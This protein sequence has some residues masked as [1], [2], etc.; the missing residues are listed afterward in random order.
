MKNIQ[1]LLFIFCIIAASLSSCKLD[2]YDEP[3]G[4]ITGR[5]I[6]SVT[7]EPIVTEQP[8][9]FRI[10][11]EE[12]SWSDAPRPEYFWGKADGT[13]NNIRL[14]SGTY[15]VTPVEGA[16]DTPG[17]KEVNITSGGVT[18][19]D[20]TVTPYISFSDVSIV[21]SGDNIEVSFKLTKNIQDATL[22][23]YRIFATYKTPFV[24]TVIFES[25]IY[26]GDN[27]PKNSN[28]IKLTEADLNKTL[29]ETLDKITPG[30]LWYV[31]V[32]ARC[33]N[34]SSRYNMS[35]V[36]PIQM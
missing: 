17:A 16:F 18:T 1:S 28:P 10:K 23:D 2:N 3:D 27:N 13:F 22:Q 5:V 35:K 11:L 36:F 31:R 8:D 24:G 14:F 33:S 21:K 32:G 6:D 34:S 7:G 19:V 20:F 9:G 15:K 26:S 25:A 4:T 30:K 29:T 12:I